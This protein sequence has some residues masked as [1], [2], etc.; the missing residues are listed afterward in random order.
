[1]IVRAA[2]FF[3]T[4]RYPQNEELLVFPSAEV[5]IRDEQNPD[6]DRPRE[7][8]LPVQRW[9]L[10]KWDPTVDFTNEASCCCNEGYRSGTSLPSS[11]IQIQALV[12]HST[13]GVPLCSLNS[14]NTT[15]PRHI[16]KLSNTG[17][18]HS[19]PVTSSAQGICLSKISLTLTS[20]HSWSLTLLADRNPQLIGF[21]NPNFRNPHANTTKSLNVGITP[22]LITQEGPHTSCNYAARFLTLEDRHST[23]LVFTTPYNQI[24]IMSLNKVRSSMWNHYY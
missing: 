14:L 1:M 10:V 2:N 24:K 4:E 22:S 11:M 9:N 19:Q 6:R 5:E 15:Y 16:P 12:Y 3:N 7:T 23:F 17:M 18:P 20:R 21:P 8:K 13:H